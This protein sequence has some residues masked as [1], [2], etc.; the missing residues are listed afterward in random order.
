MGVLL[1]EIVV[2]LDE[3]AHVFP[4]T[5]AQ[6]RQPIVVL[7]L[8]LSKPRP[9]DDADARRVK[10]RKRIERIWFFT[11][12]LCSLDCLVGQVDSRV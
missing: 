8:F 1:H 7:S 3:F 11:S 12:R 10:Q 2:E 5:R 9:G 6:A 4:H